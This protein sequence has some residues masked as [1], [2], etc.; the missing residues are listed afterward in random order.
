MSNLKEAFDL[1]KNKSSNLFFAE[2]SSESWKKSENNFGSNVR[3]VQLEFDYNNNP[4]EVPHDEEEQLRFIMQVVQQQGT[5][6]LAQAGEAFTKNSDIWIEFFAKYPLLFNF[7]QR[8][9]KTLTENDF[10]LSVNTKLVETCIDAKAPADIKAAFIQALQ[11]SSGEVLSTTKKEQNLEYLA[12][13]RTYDKASTL[14]I[15]KAELQMKVKEVKSLCGGIK[16]VDL[17]IIYDRIVFEINNQLA[18]A[19]YPELSKDAADLATKYLSEF[20]Q[21][22]AKQEFQDFENWLDSLGK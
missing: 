4:E 22:F 3:D 20:F 1:A 7:Q 13:I 12:L 21:Q 14:T 18:L 6:K 11:D 5:N 10:S 17:K 16:T 19:I 8:E 2:P 9:S 15:Y